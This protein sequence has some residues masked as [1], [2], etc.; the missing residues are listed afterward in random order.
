M[1]SGKEGY[2]D[3]VKWISG[4]RRKESP[5]LLL[6]TSC[7]LVAI[8][9]RWSARALQDSCSLPLTWVSILWAKVIDDQ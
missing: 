8:L 5:T 7:T 2:I 4:L 6:P 9:H 1:V 3:R